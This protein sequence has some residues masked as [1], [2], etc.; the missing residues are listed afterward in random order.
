MPRYRYTAELAARAGTDPGNW[1][2]RDVQRTNL[3]GSL[4]PPDGAA[5]PDDKLFRKDMFPYSLGQGLTL[6]ILG[7]SR[8][9]FR[10][11]YFRMVGC[12]ALRR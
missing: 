11:R 5:V 1:P 10:A 6:V 12:N 9:T 4:A 2:G 3:V 7:A 8:P